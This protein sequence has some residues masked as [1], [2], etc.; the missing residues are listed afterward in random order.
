MPDESTTLLPSFSNWRYMRWLLATFLL[1]TVGL[2]GCFGFNPATGGFD[3]VP[4]EDFEPTGKTVHLKASVADWTFHEIFPGF[5][6]N[7]WAF[8]M[9]AATPGDKYS[10]DAIEYWNPIESDGINAPDSDLSKSLNGKCSVPAPTLRVQQG[11]LVKVDFANQHFHC[12]TIHWHGQYVPWDDD[13]VPG[14]N[15]DST[16]TGETFNYEFVA[17]RAGTLWYHCHV[18]TQ[19]HVMQGLFG[20]FIVEPQDQR[21]EPKDIDAEYKLIFSTL[22]REFVQITEI[23]VA[24]PHINHKHGGCGM[25]GMQNCQNPSVDLEPDTWMLNGRSIPNT[26]EDM[27]DTTMVVNEGDRV[28]VRLLNA[29]E[30]VETFHTHGHDMYVTHIDGNP[31]HPNARYYV[32]TLTIG[33]AQR[34]DFVIDMTQ[35]GIWVAHTHVDNHVTNS[36]QAPGGAHTM[37]VYKDVLDAQGGDMRPFKAELFG[38]LPYVRPL[39][40]PGDVVVNREIDV[41]G[42][43]SPLT[44]GA[45]D[46]GTQFNISL[47]CAVRSMQVDLQWRPQLAHPQE[48]LTVDILDGDGRVIVENAPLVNNQFTFKADPRK[49]PFNPTAPNYGIAWQPGDFTVRLQGTGGTGTAIVGIMADY[50]LE[51]SEFTFDSRDVSGTGCDPVDRIYDPSPAKP[52]Y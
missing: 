43:A 35:P 52:D 33:P 29:G 30:T 49:D 51:E 38:G 46:A 23:T 44:L 34:Y 25:S 50:F 41:Q 4:G 12:H 2:S 7:M 16:C 36:G 19:F 9:E 5:M 3:F 17:S 27:V 21:W 28:R 37:I 8:C 31:L 6:A 1:L 11:D 13:G 26:M 20:M 22:K 18:D 14:V 32:D 24:D 15:Q 39:A 10:E 40:I 47:P 48:S 42:S 45:V